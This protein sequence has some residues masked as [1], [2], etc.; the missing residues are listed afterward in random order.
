MSGKAGMLEARA[1][2]STLL[3]KSEKSRTLSVKSKI[4]QTPSA[5]SRGTKK[6]PTAS[7][8]SAQKKKIQTPFE[9][10]SIV[11]TASAEFEQEAMP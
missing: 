5:K 1:K 2:C 6:L 10:F 3:S 9:Q 11:Q 4:L 7:G 8:E